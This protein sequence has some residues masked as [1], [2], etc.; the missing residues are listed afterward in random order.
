[1][2]IGAHESW[3]GSAEN[4]PGLARSSRKT[5]VLSLTLRSRAAAT[6][7]GRGKS[8]DLQLARRCQRLVEPALDHRGDLLVV[9]LLHHHVAIAMDADLGK[10]D[11]GRLEASLLQILD[12][13]MV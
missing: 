9:L 5:F 10:P 6:A 4:H 11:P 2:L 8:A 13:A 7:G 3:L 12:S 1:M